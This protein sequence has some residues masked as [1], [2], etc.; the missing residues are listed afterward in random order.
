M[1]PLPTTDA[2][3]LSD[4]MIAQITQAVDAGFDAQTAFLADFVRI[5]SLRFEEG[6]AQDFMADA[7]RKR[8]Y[9][10]DDW[11]IHL[12]DLEPLPGFGPIMGD[13]SRARS[14]VGTHQPQSVKGRSLILQGHLDVV[15]AGPTDMWETHPFDPVIRDGWMHGRGAGD[16]KSGTVAALFAL[17]ALA[18]AGLEPAARVHFQSVIEEES[19]GLGALSTLQRGYRADVA[20]L[21]EPSDFYINRAQIGVLWFRL[22]VRGRP[23]HVAVA[24]DGSNAIMASMDVIK[25][26][27]GLEAKWNERAA[28]DPVYGDVPHPLNFNAG[29]IKGGDW[30]SSVPAW[31][32]VDCRMGVLPGQDLEAAK[33]E[34]A[35]CVADASRDHPFLSNNPPEVIWNGFQAEGYVLGEDADPA[36]DVMRSAYQSVFGAEE[37]LQESKMTALTDTRFYGLYYGIPSFCIGPR[38]QNIHGFDE[39]VE[40][41]S[42]R[43]LTK[44]LALFI[45]EWC[46]VN[47]RQ[48]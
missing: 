20:V 25:A 44:L 6:P 7:L 39:R 47:P 10:V 42:V 28:A 38:A 5:P 26:L 29:K 33:A 4:D 11:T 16:M 18:A 34:I 24:G 40:L 8:G 19:T 2:A 41:E 17:D 35:A 27:Q 15:P 3:P 21:P 37:A 32:D 13:F 1:E 22:A 30:A 23:V 12:S 36:L 14:V 9:S 31:C 46:G 48:G 45:A 43:Q